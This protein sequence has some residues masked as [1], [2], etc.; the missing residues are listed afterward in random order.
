MRNVG[1]FAQL[2]WCCCRNGWIMS[3]S[4]VHRH[5]SEWQHIGREWT[6]RYVL[7]LHGK[8]LVVVG[9]QKKPLQRETRGCPVPVTASSSFFSGSSIQFQPVLASQASSSQFQPVPS[10]SSHL[11]NRP[12]VSQSWANL[13][14]WWWLWRAGGTAVKTH[15]RKGK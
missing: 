15:S 3:R 9:P 4:H 2:L 14:S 11:C 6:F 13:L 8:V 5:S 10:S 12:T 1:L 7:G